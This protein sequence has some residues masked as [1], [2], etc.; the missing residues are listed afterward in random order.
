LTSPHLRGVANINMDTCTCGPY[1]KPQASP[2]LKETTGRE[3]LYDK[4]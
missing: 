2:L 1:V 4:T 3:L